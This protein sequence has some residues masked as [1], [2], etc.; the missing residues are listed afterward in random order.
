M[1]HRRNRLADCENMKANVVLGVLACLLVI[2]AWWDVRTRRIPNGLIVMGL[3]LGVL[4][5]EL[6]PS[7]VGFNSEMLPGG[8]GWNAAVQG[9]G[10]GLIL[11]L[12]L[13]W[14][15]A[16]G[17]GDVKLMAVV[18]AFVGPAGVIGAALL[19]LLVGGAMALLVALQGRML[20]RLLQNVRLLLLGGIVKASAGQMP[21]M[22]DL[23][24]SVGKL[25]YGVA[26]AAGTLGWL[27]WQRMTG[28]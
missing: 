20:G 1:W 13:Y 5:N 7:G 22:Q 4:V 23:P 28:V 11:F 15:R 10:L 3:L 9:A 8:L 17:A 27:A 14:L 24:V 19:T 21:S 18:G 16:M 25:P 26:I 12:P 2:A 6:L